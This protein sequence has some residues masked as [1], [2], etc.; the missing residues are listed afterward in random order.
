MAP[1]KA[2]FTRR[3]FFARGV[4]GWDPGSGAAPYPNR[5]KT[6]A[7][8]NAA[9]LGGVGN[10]REGLQK[11]RRERGDKA[12]SAQI[13]ER[14]PGGMRGQRRG[15]AWPSGLP[16]RGTAPGGGWIARHAAAGW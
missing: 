7:H 3:A 5:A 14:R 11:G 12:A 9:Q 6:P 15:A 10:A 1:T 2:P 13:P 4:G 8:G 16:Q